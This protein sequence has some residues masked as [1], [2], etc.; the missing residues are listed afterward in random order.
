MTREHV[1]L[2]SGSSNIPLAKEIAT[3][4]GIKLGN[5][6]IKQFP[7]GEIDIELLESVRGCEVFVLQTIALRPNYFLMELLMIIETL[8]RASAKSI[9]AVMPYF[10]Y[11]RQD[12]RGHKRVPITAKLVSDMLEVAGTTHL[13]TM[14]LHAPQVQGFFNIGVDELQAMPTFIRTLQ[15]QNFNDYVV[16]TP[17]IGSVKFANVF[18]RA[19]GTEYMI[20]DKARTSATEVSVHKLYGSVEGKNILLLDD[21]C[22]TAATLVAAAIACM[23]AGAKKINAVI[24]HGLFVD[25][26]L[27]KINDSP[28]EKLFVTNT[29]APREEVLKCSK[30]EPISIAQSFAEGISCIVTGESL[31]SL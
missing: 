2:F 4:G 17:D 9:T 28:I 10:G 12:R 6:S 23:D 13:L 20:I 19:A 5:I 22:S 27:E 16:V 24:T 30:I 25:G 31:T 8:R 21:I 11:C 1:L 7:D 18:A 3:R 26:A 29:I 14:D 15:E